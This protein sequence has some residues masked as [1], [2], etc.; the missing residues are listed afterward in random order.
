MHLAIAADFSAHHVFTFDFR[1]FIWAL[2]PMGADYCYAIAHVM[3]GEYAARLLNFVML[4]TIVWLIY[5]QSRIWLSPGVAFVISALFASG[6]MVQLVTGSILV[7]NFIAAVALG[8][9]V[10]LWRFHESPS[11]RRLA[12]CSFLAGT[13]VGWKIGAVAIAVTV[14]L[15]WSR[16]RYGGGS[17]L[18]GACVVPAAGFRLFP[19]R[20]SL[21]AIRESALSFCQ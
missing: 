11:A 7:E 13:A 18:G 1:Q 14:L 20:E 10:A 19:A 15:I 17:A 12:L 5:R 21:R 8:A 16:R 9:G 2:M 4:V 3:G 6:S